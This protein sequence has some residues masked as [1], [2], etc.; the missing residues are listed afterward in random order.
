MWERSHWNGGGKVILENG[1]QRIAGRARTT[2]V[3]FDLHQKNEKG[4]RHT[5]NYYANRP[6]SV[7]QCPVG[8]GVCL[9]VGVGGARMRTLFFRLI[10]AFFLH[11]PLIRLVCE[12]AL[13]FFCFYACTNDHQDAHSCRLI[14]I[15]L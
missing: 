6:D 13:S 1:V 15:K 12:G 7:L 10:S 2:S 11:F 5:V 8:L 9:S 14:C 3:R 4:T